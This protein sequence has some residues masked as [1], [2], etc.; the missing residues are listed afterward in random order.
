MILLLTHSEE[1]KTALK[2]LLR[3]YPSETVHDDWL[4]DSMDDA[5]STLTLLDIMAD[6]VLVAKEM[7]KA[8]MDRGFASTQITT[9]QIL[10]SDLKPDVPIL[11]FATELCHEIIRLLPDR[12]L[13]MIVPNDLN[14]PTF[15]VPPD[16]HAQAWT[17]YD[18]PSPYWSF[19]ASQTAYDF[20][21]R[22]VNYRGLLTHESFQGALPDLLKERSYMVNSVDV[23]T[24]FSVEDDLAYSPSHPRL[25]VRS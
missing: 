10:I 1:N 20:Q 12:T 14:S 23:K 8:L 4:F 24:Q 16:I 6:S 5:G 25:S 7:A 3:S 21:G 22:L 13:Q 15:L 9:I 11:G 17:V 2:A 18:A 19:S